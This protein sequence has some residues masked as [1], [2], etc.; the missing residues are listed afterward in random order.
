MNRFGLARTIP[1]S[2]KLAVRQRDGFGC[3]LC[4]SAL[5]EYEHFE[6]DF[7]DATEHLA[8]GIILLC[9]SCHGRKTRGHL[10]RETL[11]RARQAPK[12]KED[13]FSFSAFDVGDDPP[14]VILG[15][16][17]ATN[18]GTLLG[19]L[20]DD[21]LRIAPP[22][23]SGG[24]FRIS[25]RIY[26]RASRPILEIIENEWR[27]PASNWDVSVIGQR[28]T[29]R[30]NIR[31]IDLV[32][33]TD[34]PNLLT[35]ERLRMNHR[36]VSI[37]CRPLHPTRIVTPAGAVIETQGMVLKGCQTAIEI[38]ETGFAIGV[39]GGSVSF[40]ETIFNPREAGH[41]RPAT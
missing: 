2:V 10:S 11:N 1:E 5:V 34:P 39:G 40:R 23:V 7:K 19:V 35:V 30:S 31:D 13:G 15:N 20:G 32:L 25:A 36:G 4:G 26:D 41:P 28:I 8:D 16:I 18:V 37:D 24:P 17:E 38:S 6:P 22:E 9:T 21:I 33:R 3:I 12:A 14:T 29:I 27:T